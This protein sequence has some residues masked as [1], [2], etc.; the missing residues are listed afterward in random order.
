[1][2]K[3]ISYNYLLNEEV[4]NISD[5]N[6]ILNNKKHLTDKSIEVVSNLKKSLNTSNVLNNI[7]KN[8]NYLNFY[9]H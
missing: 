4:I 8:I 2:L 1:M 3:E 6:I 5:E 7:I 9:Y